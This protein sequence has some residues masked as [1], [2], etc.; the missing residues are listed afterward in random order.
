MTVQTPVKDATRAGGIRLL[1]STWKELEAIQLRRGHPFLN[2]TLREAVREFIA[3][4]RA[5]MKEAA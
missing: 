5:M 2:D 1:G 3:N 4:D